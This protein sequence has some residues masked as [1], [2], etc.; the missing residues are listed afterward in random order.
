MDFVNSW[1]SW[2]AGLRAAQTL[3]LGGKARALLEGRSHVAMED[4]A[5]LAAPTLRHRVLLNYKAEA[6]GIEIEHCIKKLLDSIPA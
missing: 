5:A 6:E 1:V 4:I 2:G 3:V